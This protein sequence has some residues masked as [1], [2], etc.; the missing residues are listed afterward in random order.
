[1]GLILDFILHNLTGDRFIQFPVGV[2]AVK[3]QAITVIVIENE[4]EHRVLHQVVK[5]IGKNTFIKNTFI[6]NTA[7]KQKYPFL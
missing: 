5:T 7:H 3:V 1:M 2:G 6:K 4:W